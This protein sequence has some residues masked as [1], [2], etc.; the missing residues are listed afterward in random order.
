MFHVL[1]M[2]ISFSS[3]LPI[4]S[5]CTAA[6]I[7]SPSLAHPLNHGLERSRRSLTRDWLTDQIPWKMIRHKPPTCP[8]AARRSKKA[9]S[10]AAVCDRQGIRQAVLDRM[11]GLKIV[12]S[13]WR[14]RNGSAADQALSATFVAHQIRAKTKQVAP[15]V[16]NPA[17]SPRCAPS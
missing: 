13:D 10:R 17:R 2:P 16:Y 7:F 3:S 14:S 15:S 12:G 11:W 9:L 5:C 4:T 8:A 1:I 6:A